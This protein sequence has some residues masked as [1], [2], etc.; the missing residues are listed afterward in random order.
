[1][2][3]KGFF[4]VISGAILVAFGIKNSSDNEF[5]EK[6]DSMENEITETFDIPDSWVKN[7]GVYLNKISPETKYVNL[8]SALDATKPERNDI[9]VII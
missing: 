3:R 6:R 7:G 8:Q 5:I 9:I 1:M 2:T 4:G